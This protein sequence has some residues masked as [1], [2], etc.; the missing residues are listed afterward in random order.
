MGNDG[1]LSGGGGA[2][3]ESQR[4]R[5]VRRSESVGESKRGVL[6]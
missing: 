2:G 3:A 4:C 6:S 5:A 1:G